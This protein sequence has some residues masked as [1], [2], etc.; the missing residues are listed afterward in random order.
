MRFKV[1]LLACIG[2]VGCNS[3]TSE[4]DGITGGESGAPQGGSGPVCRAIS[5]RISTVPFTLSIGDAAGEGGAGG[6]GGASDGSGAGRAQGCTQG[7]SGTT[8]CSGNVIRM[9]TGFIFDDG[10]IL[11]WTGAADGLA[12]PETP[13]G[14]IPWVEYE[15]QSFSFC[16]FC[17]GYTRKAISILEREGE[18]ALYVGS[19]NGQPLVDP[20]LLFDAAIEFSPKCDTAP[21]NFDCY[22]VVDHLFDVVVGTDPVQLVPYGELTRIDAPA[23][24]FDV[25]WSIAGADGTYISGCFDGRSPSDTNAV[26]ALRGPE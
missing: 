12:L 24:S 13:A 5:D 25:F 17:G 20:S 8:T 3:R 7:V 11:T 23:G 15:E 9:R 6:V 4:S 2:F 1:L 16:P 19:T 22:T 26:A 18:L 21:Y 10:S 14:A